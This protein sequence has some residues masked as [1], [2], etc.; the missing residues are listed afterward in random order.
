MARTAIL[1][2]RRW[3]KSRAGW[4]LI[5]D[6]NWALGATYL[7]PAV[8]WHGW[9][10]GC[11]L[12]AFYGGTGNDL[13]LPL[14]ILQLLFLPGTI[15]QWLNLGTTGM[16]PLPKN[17]FTLGL[18]SS[19]PASLLLITAFNARHSDLDLPLVTLLFTIA[20]QFA[21]FL[22]SFF[23]IQSYVSYMPLCYLTT[24]CQITASDRVTYMMS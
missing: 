2:G 21:I 6:G 20:S 13:L 7:N 12:I 8:K 4:G 23:L 11:H 9:L 1:T 24:C 15:S 10:W 18:H 5:L 16:I 14:I 22:F 17:G 3:I 19:S